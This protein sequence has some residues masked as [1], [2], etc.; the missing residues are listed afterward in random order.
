MMPH[1][2]PAR[3]EHIESLLEGLD[4]LRAEIVW[5]AIGMSPESVAR[6]SLEGATAAWVWIADGRVACMFGVGQLQIIG[7]PIGWMLATDLVE[8]YRFT[9]IR[10]CRE[11]LKNMLLLHPAI[12]AFVDI[13]FEKSVNWMKWMGFQVADHAVP[14]QNT[15]YFHACIGR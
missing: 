3:P 12:E 14:F 9:F 7:P 13:R 5:G 2:E 4:H 15:A 10:H 1:I 8:K 11:A 6:E